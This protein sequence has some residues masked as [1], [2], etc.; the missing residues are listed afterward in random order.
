MARHAAARAAAKP[1]DRGLGICEADRQHMHKVAEF[2]KAELVK[3]LV[4]ATKLRLDC[5]AP[6]A[7]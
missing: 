7:P 1:D 2:R 3:C 5:P 6:L 4:H